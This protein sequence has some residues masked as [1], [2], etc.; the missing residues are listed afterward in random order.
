[1]L[2]HSRDELSYTLVD[3]DAAPSEAT[4]ARIRAIEGIL[5]VRALPIIDV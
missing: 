5:S 2:N 1:M 4:L 3:L